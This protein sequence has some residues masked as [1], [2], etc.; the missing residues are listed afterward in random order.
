MVSGQSAA[1]SVWASSPLK[2]LVPRPRGQSVWAYLSSYGGGLVAGD[3]TSV[4]LELAARTRCFLSTQASTKVYRNPAGRPCGHRLKAT[5][6][7]GSVLALAPDPVQAFAGSSY[8]QRQE[9]HLASGSGLVLV[10][11]L[12]SGRMARGE[13]WVFDCF[14]SRNDIFLGGERVFLDSLLLN[15]TEVP[16]TGA[17][18]MGRFNCLATVLLIGEP[19][20][21]ASAKMLQDFAT[22]PVTR[23]A[24]LL[25]SASPIAHGTL[26]RLAGEEV[27]EVG[28]EIHRQLAF[29]SGFLHDD[30]WSK[31]W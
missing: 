23:A 12:C 10:D 27:E 8:T 1:T 6:G 3:E 26:L 31:K 29:L 25:Y 15:S 5:L 16:L 4:T 14:R 11:W 13:R 22:R 28:R 24:S 30:P 9:F 21:T 19:L 7:E 18:G 20:R 2:I 17:H